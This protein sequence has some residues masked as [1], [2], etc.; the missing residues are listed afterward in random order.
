MTRGFSAT[1]S[2]SDM[3]MQEVIRM[4]N[5]GGVGYSVKTVSL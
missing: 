5:S 2:S 3:K 1:R 4:N